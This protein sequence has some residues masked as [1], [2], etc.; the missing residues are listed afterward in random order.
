[1]AEMELEHANALTKMFTKEDKPA[2]M[3]DQEYA[4]TQ[5]VVMDTYVSGMGKLEN[6]K[7]LYWNV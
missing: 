6:M 7:K 3:T 1:M 2:A 4:T 5:K